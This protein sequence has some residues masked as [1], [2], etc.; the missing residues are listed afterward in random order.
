MKPLTCKK[1]PVHEHR[2][3]K[4]RLA[5]VPQLLKAKAFVRYIYY[6]TES[7]LRRNKIEHCHIC[8]RKIRLIVCGR[9]EKLKVLFIALAPD[10]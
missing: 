1:I 3:K 5:Q 6:I 4:Y 2:D 8:K 7:H 10:R 9:K